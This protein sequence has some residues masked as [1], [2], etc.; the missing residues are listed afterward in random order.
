[1]TNLFSKKQNNETG[2]KSQTRIPDLVLVIGLSAFVVTIALLYFILPSHSFSSLENRALQTRPTP[3]FNEV[4]SGTVSTE[5]DQFY[6]DQMPFRTF[7]LSEKAFLELSCGRE[8]NG[9]VILGLDG[10][11]IKRIE[12]PDLSDLSQN[13]D[14]LS[15]MSDTIKDK[16]IPVQT[17]IVPRTIDETRSYLPAW[18]DPSYCDEPW[19]LLETSGF[20]FIDLRDVLTETSTPGLWYLTDHH[21]TTDGAYEAY[22]ALGST[23]GYTPF[24]KDDFLRV[25]ATDSFKGTSYAASGMYWRPGEEISLFRYDNDETFE[26]NIDGKPSSLKGFYDFSAP[27]RGQGYEIF[28]GGNFARMTIHDPNEAKPTLLLFKDSFANALIP[29]LSRHYDLVVIDPR[30]FRGSYTGLLEEFSPAL[31][32]N[33]YGLDT[34]ANPA[35]LPK[36]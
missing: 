3:R 14:S 31:I 36:F 4:V 23:L 22:A 33:L 34:L 11:L 25:V 5:L 35:L 2:E 20:S 9:K 1:M 18:F 13:L 12:Y 19:A 7:W 16:G 24:P 17:V 6:T 29:F 27:D 32:L 30:Y 28:L 21:W 15:A 26:V 8:E 10:R